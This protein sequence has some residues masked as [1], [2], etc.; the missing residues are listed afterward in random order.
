[1]I[2][3]LPSLDDLSFLDVLPFTQHVL[4]GSLHVLD[5]K[6]SVQR[7]V[8]VVSMPWG[9][10][11]SR[12]L[13]DVSSQM[14]GASREDLAARVV[15]LGAVAWKRIMSQSA[16]KFDRILD[17]A[18]RHALTDVQPVAT[19]RTVSMR[20]KL[21]I[22]AAG[23]FKGWGET[24]IERRLVPLLAEKLAALPA[25][26]KNGNVAD[27]VRESLA[28]VP[29]AMGDLMQPIVRTLIS[30]GILAAQ[31]EGGGKEAS[32]DLKPLLRPPIHQVLPMRVVPPRSK[33][34]RVTKQTALIYS[35]NPLPDACPICVEI[36]RRGPFSTWRALERIDEL[37]E[38]AGTE[39]I[40]NGL[41]D[42]SSFVTLEEVGG[43]SREEL[44]RRGIIL[45]PFHHQCFTGQN[46]TYAENV[47]NLVTRRYKG[48]I[49]FIGVR[50]RDVFTCT[51]NHPIFTPHGR[52][53]AGLLKPG[54]Y[55]LGCSG[56]EWK[57]RF[58]D[59]NNQ[60]V[61][62][63]LED[64]AAAVR[65]S[66]EVIPVP[67]PISAPDFHGDGGLNREVA[68]VYSDRP[69]GFD[70]DAL[71]F[72]HCSEF[73]FSRACEVTTSG[74]SMLLMLSG[75]PN[76]AYRAICPHGHPFPSIGGQRL[77]VGTAARSHVLP[78]FRRHS[79]RGGFLV[80][81][82]RNSKSDQS[83]LDGL[84]RRTTGGSNVFNRF[85][86]SITPQEVLIVDKE[87]FWHG[88]VY[89]ME[90]TTGQYLVNG[91]QVSNCRCGISLG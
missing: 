1:M 51:P 6:K 72:E 32:R 81:S 23:W 61:P 5:D 90:T 62:S 21:R 89:N 55:V 57:S 77:Y 16:D 28:V 64:L 8:S 30:L 18:L 29:R 45:P 47:R 53:A 4:K 38:M 59:V 36:A 79:K 27:A 68:V 42:A 44:E 74:S 13:A 9:L 73:L 63:R 71:L 66:S 69:L 39:D 22:I 2:E 85:S 31:E 37:A 3:P 19:E 91:V 14:K 7:A 65:M 86:L 87:P 46:D 12:I 40:V 17:D 88:T 34:E 78:Y 83:F 24:L 15:S 20:R 25:S 75:L 56:S 52:V 50:G 43:K 33:P 49:V 84:F 35:I 11:T 10:A 76:P 70:R 80:C 41:V 60:K 58:D 82:Q 67:V 26:A 54:D 48:P